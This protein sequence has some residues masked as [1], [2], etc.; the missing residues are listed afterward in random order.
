[1]DD[2]QEAW[3]GVTMEQ[4]RGAV[5]HLAPALRHPYEMLEFQRMKYREIAGALNLHI[6]T[7]KTRVRRAREK[8]RDILVEQRKAQEAS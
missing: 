3:A 2:N 7:V 1:M 8:L 5:D 4:V 6:D